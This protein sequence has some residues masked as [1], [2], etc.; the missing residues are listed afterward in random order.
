M[1]Q[2]LFIKDVAERV[3]IT[4]SAVRYF[5]KTRRL[6]D[7]RFGGRVVF[8]PEIIDAFIKE[9]GNGFPKPGRPK[10]KA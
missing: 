6:P 10:G 3:G 1:T 5:I 4:V 7:Y 9:R 2:F 8:S